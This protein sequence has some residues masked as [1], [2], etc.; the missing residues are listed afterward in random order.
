MDMD[1]VITIKELDFSSF[2]DR[3]YPSIFK[4]NY[5]SFVVHFDGQAVI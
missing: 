2:C 3:S 5:T 4:Y 1:T